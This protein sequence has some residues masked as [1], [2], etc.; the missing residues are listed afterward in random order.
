ML[1]YGTLGTSKSVALGD[2]V[3]F[4]ATQL[5]LAVN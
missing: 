5:T 4:N 2:E 3:R 1:F